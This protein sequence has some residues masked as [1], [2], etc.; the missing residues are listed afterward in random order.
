M[1]S[2]IPTAT[3]FA[4]VV[5]NTITHVLTMSAYGDWSFEK[6]HDWQLL[7]A[8]G[9]WSIEKKHEF[10]IVGL[11]IRVLQAGVSFQRERKTEK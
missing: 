10:A 11:T 3:K 1:I 8:H 7:V 5:T 9:G 4:I 6:K 2:Q